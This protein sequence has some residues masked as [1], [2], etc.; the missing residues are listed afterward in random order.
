MKHRQDGSNQTA[1]DDAEHQSVD[2]DKKE[3]LRETAAMFTSVLQES[4]LAIAVVDHEGKVIIWNPAAERLFGWTAAEALESP[5]ANIPSETRRELEIMIEATLEGETFTGVETLLQ[6][7]DQQLINVALSSAPFYDG[8]GRILGTMA[9]MVD[10]SYLKRAEEIM[11][12]LSRAGAELTLSLEVTQILESLAGLALP[13]LGDYIAIDLQQADGTIQRVAT[14]H[15]DPAKA[16]VAEALR[17][18]VPTQRQ[19][20]IRPRTRPGQPEILPEV[21]DTWLVH[22]AQSTEHLRLMRRLAPRSIMIVPLHVRDRL[23]GTVMLALTKPGRRYGL[24]DL[25]LAQELTQ[26]AALAIDN[27]N[28]FE[29]TRQAVQA[30]DD[31]L[32]IV[33]HD[34]RNPIN[35]ISMTA[36]LLQEQTPAGEGARLLE[37]IQRSTQRMD[38]LIRDLLDVARI[39]A[40]GITIRPTDQDPAELVREAVELQQPLAREEE[41]QLTAEIPQPLPTID[42]DRDR[43]LQVFQ[44]L[45]ENALKF[46]PRNGVITVRAEPAP[47]AVRLSVRDSGSGIDPEELPHLFDR[48]WQ[49]RK[50]TKAGAGLGLA[51][52]RGIVE[53]HGGRIQ[54]ESRLGV[55]TTITFTIPVH[56]GKFPASPLSPA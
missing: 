52:A 35:T 16:A 1:P 42:A 54:A 44:N 33:S 29:E 8:Q 6:R 9:V 18:Y 31:V 55:G 47:D 38:R 7:K 43:L 51:I 37:I 23:L 20:Y 10:I 28:L 17:Q 19:A 32:A 53:A 41:I 4:P 50:T 26:R 36:E 46:T 25:Q 2:L 11:G 56:P 12:F 39:E 27:A 15:L 22:R 24:R 3:R 30:R 40:G 34:L 45:L 49:A 21:S 5:L 48:F 13:M 14:R